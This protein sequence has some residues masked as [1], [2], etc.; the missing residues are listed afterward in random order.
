[1][2]QNHAK[3]QIGTPYPHNRDFEGALGVLPP[4]KHIT[5]DGVVPTLPVPVGSNRSPDR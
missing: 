3:R 1:M 5:R 4:G 2:G